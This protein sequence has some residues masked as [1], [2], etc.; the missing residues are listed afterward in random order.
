MKEMIMGAYTIRTTQHGLEVGQESQPALT[1]TPSEVDKITRLIGIGL[2][3]ESMKGLP[4]NI[5]HSPFVL[6]FFEDNTLRLERIDQEGSLL[7]TFSKGDEMIRMFRSALSIAVDEKR[8]EELPSG[9][10]GGGMED[11][12]A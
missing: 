9:A 2:S 5:K 3:M 8:L 10:I 6:R 11:F 7:F 1:L 4:S 12:I